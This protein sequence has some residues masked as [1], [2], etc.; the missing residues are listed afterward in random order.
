MRHPWISP[1]LAVPLLLLASLAWF[2][3][4]RDLGER[5]VGSTATDVYRETARQFYLGL[6][7][8]EVGLLVDA[9][10]QFETAAALA[11]TE[12][13]IPANLAVAHLRLGEEAPAVEAL[14]T[15]RALAP[16]D[17]RLALLAGLVA[18]FGGR[19]EE[20]VTEFRAAVGFDPEL[21]QARY[22][23]AQEL[24]Q[25]PSGAALDEAQRQLTEILARRSDNLPV[26]VE[27]VRV[28]A[29][30]GDATAV[31][32][33]VALLN[34]VAVGWP[35]PAMGQLARLL[36]VADTGQ[37]AEAA[38]ATALLRNVL[39]RLGAYQD[40]L[41]EVTVDPELVATPLDRFL[42]LP[43]PP[44]G[45]SPSDETLT[46]VIE[47]LAAPAA[48]A[49]PE[50][51]AGAQ[52]TVLAVQASITPTVTI[53]AST[54]DR[55][56]VPG[57]AAVAAYPGG[58]A[59]ATGPGLLAA[60]WTN[61]F[62]KDLALAG[63]TG[64]RIFTQDPDGRFVETTPAP[65]TFPDLDQPAFGVWAADLEMDGDLDLVVALRDDPPQVLRNNGDGTWADGPQF[66]ELDAVRGFAWGDLD[67]D[68]DPDA[69]LVDRSGVAAFYENRQAGQFR[70]WPSPELP[71]PLLAVT[72]GDLDVDGRLEVLGL[73]TA[74]DIWRVFRRG[75]DW[76]RARVAEWSRPLTDDPGRYRLLVADLDNNGAADLMATGPSGTDVW[77]MD[78]A[79]PRPLEVGAEVEVFSIAD[80]DG[81]GRLDLVG[82]QDGG[83][84]RMLGRGEADYHWQVVRLRALEAAGDQRINAFGVGGE[85]DVRAG[86]LVQKQ[87]LSGDPVHFGLGDREQV[88]VVRV[89]WPN[90]V[91]QA[92]FPTTVDQAIEAEQRLK[93]SCPWLFANDGEAVRFVTDFLWRSP[94]GLRINAQDTAGVT[95]TEDWVRIGGD[96]LRPIDGEY[97]LRITAELWE[98]HFFDHVSL[99]VVDHPE[100]AEVFVDE[101]FSA[102]HPPALTLHSTATPG[103]VLAAWDD[104]GREMTDVVAL[105]DGRYVA[106]FERG[107]YQGVTRDHFLELEVGVDGEAPPTRL[108]AYGWVYPTDSS[109]NV[110]IAQGSHPAP[111][112]VALEAR[113]GAGEWVTVH[114]DLGF[115]SGK[116]KTVVVD[117]TDVPWHGPTQRL[118]LRTN[119]EVYWDWVAVADSPQTETIRTERVLPV[120]ADLRYRGFSRTRDAG[121]RGPE[122][123]AYDALANT[124]PRWRDLVGY[125]TR[126][127]DVRELLAEVDDRYVIMN[128]GD[129]IRLR[130]PAP[131]PPPSGWTRDFVLVGDGWVK[132][133]DYN[134]GFSKTVRPLPSH[135]DATY[136]TPPGEL[137]QDPVYRRHPDDWRR[138][139]TRYVTPSSFLSG[140][141]RY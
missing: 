128:A 123:P 141:Q 40:G 7:S 80:L 94:L 120:V 73:D 27:H 78:A 132:D 16:E 138:F 54:G 58:G 19:F 65:D 110:A 43:P 28:A 31:T 14:Q 77:Q 11:P 24:Q 67:L 8:L 30:R 76:D 135:A 116:N 107:A 50:A 23:L 10:T 29:D 81:D 32:D 82:V 6:A 129:E 59:P 87:L 96:Q 45:A 71:A 69:V 95:Q 46:F 12:P 63:A 92:E 60:D 57:G 18:R 26:L 114:P 9:V 124:A 136:D 56:E 51:P 35:A 5:S 98:T 139:H 33:T 49:A 44:S 103:P 68:G 20:A 101:R 111:R 126:F 15:A 86:L 127:G 134:T 121:P 117:L 79:G 1:R 38:T 74:G 89:A 39:L 4:T 99:M 22:A 52:T 75:E 41:A 85:I 84:V 90:G 48:P 70:A 108:L 13:A 42:R 55:V 25:Q 53:L 125:H 102:T 66:A 61:D 118:R 37:L 137:E 109:I 91:V 130:F 119:L 34:E 100:T 133:G 105:R 97:D 47:P 3:G 106:S 83:P 2:A 88:D 112:G 122:V 62:R 36:E 17:G 93:G 113:T 64:L 104:D 72:L 140:L 131:A 21:L 115:P